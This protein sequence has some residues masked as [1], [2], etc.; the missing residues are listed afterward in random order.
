MKRDMRLY[1][2]DIRESFIAIEEYTQKITEKEF[3]SSRQV[4]DAVIRRLEI[5][6]EAAKNV[7]QEIKLKNKTI[8]WK[9]VSGLRDILI[10]EYFGVDIDIL[11]DIIQNKLPGLK[12]ETSAILSQ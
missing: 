9:K 7:P 6:G 3:Y 10:H 8:E 2:Q 4:Q 1:L 12:T 5:I 11:W